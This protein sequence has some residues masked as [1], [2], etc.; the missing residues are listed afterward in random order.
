MNTIVSRSERT[1]S[2]HMEHELLHNLEKAGLSAKLAQQIIEARDNVL[3]IKL[4]RWLQE[5]CYEPTPVRVA[6]KIMGRL[7]G[8]NTAHQL[9][10]VEML[11]L[12]HNPNFI[13]ESLME[14]P[15]N[16]ETLA[17]LSESHILVAVFP[18]SIKKMVKHYGPGLIR[19]D[20]QPQMDYDSVTLASAPEWHLIRKSPEPDTYRQIWTI[21]LGR[22]LG[23]PVAI[24]DLH[25][26]VYAM[27]S[28]FLEEAERLFPNCLVN[29]TH[30]EHTNRV[31][32]VGMFLNDGIEITSPPNI[33]DWR[34]GGI[35][36]ER[37]KHT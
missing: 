14:V 11:G 28:Y 6:Q 20:R 16:Q 30:S 8:L 36:T 31:M 24:P 17:E 3:A 27:I 2:V 18:T 15:F 7:Y 4:V 1:L 9:G 25:T 35:A 22:L 19:S 21:Q 10:H 33:T 26:M 5:S 13:P 37:K 34:A 12:R 29:C 32:S 23:K